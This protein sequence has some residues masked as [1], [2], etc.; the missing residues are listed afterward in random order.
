MNTQP[1]HTVIAAVRQ[2]VNELSIESKSGSVD[3]VQPW[4]QQLLASLA[5]ENRNM[6]TGLRKLRTAPDRILD[7]R[8]HVLPAL[9]QKWG[10]AIWQ[11]QTEFPVELVEHE[12][13]SMEK[14]EASGIRAMARYTASGFRDVIPGDSQ[15][16]R[17]LLRSALQAMDRHTA[18][19]VEEA[20]EVF[21]F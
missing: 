13:P 12:L 7:F 20:Q 15:D 16:G 4:Y 2:S 17:K 11:I 14:L 3:D 1:Y 6:R 19:A 18:S 10:W 8:P 9:P 5:S 21:P